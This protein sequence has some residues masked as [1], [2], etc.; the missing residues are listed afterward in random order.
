MMMVTTTT[1]IIIIIIIM[2]IIIIIMS[3]IKVKSMRHKC[4]HIHETQP[5]DTHTA[6]H[7]AWERDQP[8][9]QLRRGLHISH[10]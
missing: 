2:M 9:P 6:H 10:D 3:K 5:W 1:I 8:F 4:K 7:A